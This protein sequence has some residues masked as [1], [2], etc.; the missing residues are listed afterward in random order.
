[1]EPLGEVQRTVIRTQRPRDAFTGWQWATWLPRISAAAHFIRNGHESEIL[2]GFKCLPVVDGHSDKHVGQRL[3]RRPNNA[4][5][6][7]PDQW[8]LEE[9]RS[10]WQRVWKGRVLNVNPD[11]RSTTPPRLRHLPCES[12][13]RDHHR[14]E[15][16]HG[17]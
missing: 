11:A 9:L 15:S 10:I 12:C 6:G 16:E 3:R 5:S 7:L 8:L 13:K 2:D 17:F 1:M 4:L 14:G